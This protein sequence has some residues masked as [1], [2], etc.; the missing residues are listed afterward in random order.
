MAARVSPV[1]AVRYTD[2]SAK[3]PKKAKG[4]HTTAKRAVS[5][6]KLPRM[7]WK[8]LGR[9]RGKTVITVISLALAVVLMQLTYTFA[10]GFDMDKYLASKSAVDFIVGDAA[11]FQTASGF[12]STDEAV[13]ENVIADIDAQGGITQS[14]ASTGRYPACRSLSRGLVPTE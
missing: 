12:S 2:A 8:N 10:I 11:Y 7:A 13:P 5:G 4:R 1:E 3:Q 9:S 14:G 6:A